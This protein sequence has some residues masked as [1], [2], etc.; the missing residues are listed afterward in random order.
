MATVPSE[1]RLQQ[2]LDDVTRVLDRHRV[3][4]AL[5]HRQKGPKRD[6]LEN[7]QHRQNLV[8]LHK[9]LSAMHPA[10]VAFVLE[11]LPLEDRRTVWDQIDGDRAGQVFVEVSSAV[12]AWLVERT[13]Q[14]GLI[15]LPTTKDDDPF[16]SWKLAVGS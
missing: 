12:R 16:G 13:G 8:E 9:R 10:D 7:L 1:S 6:L 11:A 4:E 5:T 3:L 14:D 15:A 2:S